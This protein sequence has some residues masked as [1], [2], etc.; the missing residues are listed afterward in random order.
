MARS[1]GFTVTDYLDVT[2]IF[3]VTC[4]AILQAREQLQEKLRA[5]EGYEG[6]EEEQRKKHSMLSGIREGL[7]RRSL[8]VATKPRC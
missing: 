8:I 5:E 3:R 1:V 4:E 2:D 7:L 6:Y